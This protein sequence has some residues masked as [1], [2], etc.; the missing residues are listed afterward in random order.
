MKVI[1][2]GAGT[3]GRIFCAEAN[4]STE[5]LAVADNNIKL[6]NKTLSGHLIISPSLIPKYSFDKIMIAVSVDIP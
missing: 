3:I 2:F 6:H 5:I 4:D 1:V